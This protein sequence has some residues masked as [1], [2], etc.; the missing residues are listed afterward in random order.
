MDKLDTC[1][2]LY[3]DLM[4]TRCVA[5]TIYRDHGYR[6]AGDEPQEFEGK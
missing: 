4:L 1:R 5:N 6:F 2:N 3:L